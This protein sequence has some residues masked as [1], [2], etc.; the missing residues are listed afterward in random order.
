MEI[1]VCRE[2]RRYIKAPN[3]NTLLVYLQSLLQPS[4]L[5]TR[6]SGSRGTRQHNT[7]PPQRSSEHSTSP[8]SQLRNEL[9]EPACTPRAPVSTED[10]KA[11]TTRLC[12]AG[13]QH[14]GNHS[15]LKTQLQL[16]S[17]C[18]SSTC[19]PVSSGFSH[20]A[21]LEK[22]GIFSQL[23]RFTSRRGLECKFLAWSDEPPKNSSSAATVKALAQH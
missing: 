18:S 22:S 15:C 13:E 1:C 14:W 20:A 4:A 21:P 16:S 5:I 9:S 10:G 6:K 2:N 19:R 23:L 11:H 7:F 17:T 12:R 3:N 8:K